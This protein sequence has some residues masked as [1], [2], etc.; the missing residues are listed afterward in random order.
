MAPAGA[1]APTLEQLQAHEAD[2]LD[3]LV[4][5]V[6]Q[7]RERDAALSEDEGELA[8][9]AER[10]REW[11]LS[12]MHDERFADQL[13]LGQLA[14]L[15]LE[16]SRAVERKN[17][18]DFEM[19]VTMVDE[20]I[21]RAK[22]RRERMEFDDSPRDA[23][24][25]V[26]TTLRSVS[27]NDLAELLGVSPRTIRQWRNTLPARPQVDADRLATLAQ[28]LYDVGPSLTSP[29][30]AVRW[31]KRPRHQLGGRSPVQ[32]LAKETPAGN[33]SLRVLARSGRGQ[34]A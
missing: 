18:D 9:E 27:P 24:K 8:E 17:Q 3:D 34:G 30:A 5:H 1:D 14:L 21:R 22:R 16:L 13:L 10:I 2:E 7:L 31:F 32:V 12:A 25:F 19:A 11:V 33:E 20:A 26:L 28:V 6:A 29:H 15:W 23:A 4:G